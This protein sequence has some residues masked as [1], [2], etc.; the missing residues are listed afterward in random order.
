L[1]WGGELLNGIAGNVMGLE[2]V[3]G[4]L[5]IEQLNPIPSIEK[6]N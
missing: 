5:K 1:W 6:N 3:R 4:I 2:E